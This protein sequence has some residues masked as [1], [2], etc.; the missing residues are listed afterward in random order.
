[1]VLYPFPMKI[2]CIIWSNYYKLYKCLHFCR[3]RD[4]N[5][6]FG[7]SGEQRD[8][9]PFI[10]ER[11]SARKGSSAGNLTLNPCHCRWE[12]AG[13]NLMNWNPDI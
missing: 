7:K 3:S 4:F 5:R 2:L 8:N 6:W 13:S 12:W 10:Q 9:D 11:E 1:M